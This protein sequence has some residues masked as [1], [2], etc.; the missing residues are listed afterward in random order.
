MF[1]ILFICTIHKANVPA[2]LAKHQFFL[3]FLFIY[4]SLTP[5]FTKISAGTD[6][7]NY[8]VLNI[9]V[10]QLKQIKIT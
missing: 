10:V 1:P 2:I 5:N 4:Y 3:T 9:L 6:V 8:C 7:Q